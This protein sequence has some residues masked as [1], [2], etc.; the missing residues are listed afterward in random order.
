MVSRKKRYRKKRFNVILL[1]SKLKHPCELGLR[2]HDTYTRY[3]WCVTKGSL[4]V[5]VCVCVPFG[6]VN[7]YLNWFEP[8]NKCS[9]A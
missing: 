2:G 5:C 7:A 9:G 4:C 3:N 1:E 6:V 8:G